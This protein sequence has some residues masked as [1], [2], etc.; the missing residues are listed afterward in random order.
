M[1]TIYLHIGMPKTGSTTLQHF[2][3]Q[4]YEALRER[5][6]L[7]PTSGRGKYDHHSQL[8][9]VAA[10]L[11]YWLYFLYLRWIES[12]DWYRREPGFD[13]LR[14]QLFDEIC[15]SGTPS[16]IL[17]SE[18]FTLWNMRGR[19][20]R[21]LARLFVGAD[22]RP[23]M[24]IRRQDE[25]IQSFY[26]VLLKGRLPI[27]FKP[28]LMK[29]IPFFRYDSVYRCWA[30]V[31]GHNKMIVRCYDQILDKDIRLDFLS[32]LNLNDYGLSLSADRLNPRLGAAQLEVLKN[33]NRDKLSGHDFQQL[34]RQQ[35]TEAGQ[36]STKYRMMTDS[37]S[38]SIMRSF[39]ESNRRLARQVFG[40]DELFLVEPI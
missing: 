1:T 24:Y 26:S 7:Y 34:T 32:V 16:V 40:R 10:G 3:R 4:N 5:G 13:R 6:Y 17:S 9:F 12:P 15:E 2:F 39:A 31:F 19:D 20:I 30:K 33:A 23:V 21:R 37:E 25:A 14:Q 8:R 36:T 22:V 27:G 28:N 18:W 29:Y 35:E 11:D 38:E